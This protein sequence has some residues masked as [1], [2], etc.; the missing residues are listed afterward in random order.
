MPFD[1]PQH[2]PQRDPFIGSAKEAQQDADFQKWSQ[3]PAGRKTLAEFLK[4]T[5]AAA[6]KHKEF[7]RRVGAN[8]NVE[9]YT[10]LRREYW[11]VVCAYNGMTPEDF[12]KLSHE[13]MY[14]LL[15]VIAR[16]NVQAKIVSNAVDRR[17]MQ[18]IDRQALYATAGRNHP[19][20][21]EHGK[22]AEFWN[23]KDIDPRAARRWL[24]YRERS[25][26]PGR[27]EYPDQSPMARKI[28][29]ALEE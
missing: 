13:E 2:N 18:T 4:V 6:N 21:F 15:E 20:R 16:K 10:A 22:A 29:T 19:G 5:I 24:T 12:Y 14:A 11:A 3:T 1:N 25:D 7:A 23:S 26:K 17:P 27:L 8:P 28:V 9:S